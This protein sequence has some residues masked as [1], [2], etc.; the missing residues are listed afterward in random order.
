MR[1]KTALLAFAAIMSVTVSGALQA[2]PAPTA[3]DS[4]GFDL[5]YGNQIELKDFEAQSGSS[6]TFT[7]NPLFADRVSSGDLPAVSDRLPVD[8]LV[9]LPF[10]QIG[11][12]GGTLRGVAGQLESGTS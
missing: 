8:A 6:L 10:D 7:G 5:Q 4:H 11:N 1:K 2:G 9:V 3:M 12:Y